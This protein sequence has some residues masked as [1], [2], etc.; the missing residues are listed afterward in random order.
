MSNANTTPIESQDSYWTALGPFVFNNYNPTAGLLYQNSGR[1]TGIAFGLGY[2][3]EK[4]LLKG[5]VYS[6]QSCHYPTRYI[7][8]QNYV[9]K[10]TLLTSGIPDDDLPD[11]FIFKIVP[12][13]VGGESVSFES[14]NYPNYYL[15][16]QNFQIKLHKKEE[17][18][19]DFKEDATFQ[20]KPGLANPVM[21]SFESVNFP[22]YFIHSDKTFNLKIVKKPNNEDALFNK[23]AT[24]NPFSVKKRMWV[25]T[26]NGGAW[27]SDDHGNSWRAAMEADQ[28]DPGDPH[29]LNTDALA[30]GAIAV[31]PADQKTIIVGSGEGN[32][33][34]KD[35]DALAF[36]G[37][38]Y[39]GMGPVRGDYNSGKLQWTLETASPSL[40]GEAFFQ[41][42][43]APDNE[44]LVIGATSQ[45]LY[46]RQKKGSDF[47]WKHSNL[48]N[49]QTNSASEPRV[50][51]VV[52]ASD[53]NT[54]TFFAACWG[55][56]IVYSNDDGK[57][58][59]SLDN[60]PDG[61]GRITL[62]VKPDDP[63]VVYALAAASD[64]S[65]LG[66][67]RNEKKDSWDG[68]K[69]LNKGVNK[70][71]DIFL[72][73]GSQGNYNQSLA[74]DPSD[75]DIFYL[76]G[77]GYNVFFCK[78]KDNKLSEKPV[79]IG[80]Y[81]GG[82]FSDGHA[83]A[84]EPKNF[85]S[86]LAIDLQALNSERLWFG[87]DGGL[88][89]YVPKKGE[90][91]KPD[92]FTQWFV[93]KNTGR[94]TLLS[95]RIGQHPKKDAV[96]Y[97]GAQDIPGQKYIG[98][99]A[100][101]F[102]PDGNNKFTDSGAVVVN[103]ADP[104]N[105]KWTTPGGVRVDKAPPIGHD[106]ERYDY[107]LKYPPFVG[108][109]YKPTKPEQANRL[110]EGVDNP[111]WQ[112]SVYIS[113][114]F[115]PDAKSFKSLFIIPPPNSKKGKDKEKPAIVRGARVRSLCFADYTTLYVG[116]MD[117]RIFRLADI[118]KDDTEDTKYTCTPTQLP[119]IPRGKVPI[120]S[121]AIDPAD[122]TGK[123][124]YVS[125]GGSTSAGRVQHYDGTNWES[126]SGDPHSHTGLLNIQ[127]NTIAIN[128]QKDPI[129][130]KPIIY[131]GTDIGVWYST[132]EGATWRPFSN[133]IPEVAV[134]NLK[135]Y[136]LIGPNGQLN[137]DLKPNSPYW[138]A[139]NYPLLR[140][141]TY[142][143]G[144]YERSLNP[145]FSNKDS[146]LFIR[147]NALDRGL[148][149]LDSQ[150]WNQLKDYTGDQNATQ[151]GTSPD[152]KFLVSGKADFSDISTGT[153]TDEGQAKK[154][155]E[156][157]KFQVDFS[158]FAFLRSSSKIPAAN[159]YTAI[160]TQVH[161]G[162]AAWPAKTT[163]YLLACKVTT[164]IPDCS[165]YKTIKSS[166]VGANIDKWTL[167]GKS[168]LSTLNLQPGTSAVFGFNVSDQLKTLK[169][170]PKKDI[171]CLLL[172][173]SD[174][175]NVF[176]ETNIRSI[177][178]N[179]RQAALSLI[180]GIIDP[181]DNKLYRTV[182]FEIKGKKQ[183]WMAE[184]LA[185]CDDTLRD[186]SWVYGQRS[187]QDYNRA[188]LEKYGRLYTWEGAQ[189]ACLPGWTV[190][191]KDDWENLA[192]HFGGYFDGFTVKPVGD[193]HKSY[194]NIIA[195]GSSGFQALLG[196]WYNADGFPPPGTGSLYWT[197]SI[198]EGDQRYAWYYGF[199]GGILSRR[200]NP[201]NYGSSVRCIM[202]P[203]L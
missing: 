37:L 27:Y 48:S 160:L 172:L 49:L 202:N 86:S 181:R 38:S 142:G 30:C 9:G 149:K 56:P 157:A 54:T 2:Q 45:G 124:V 201:L 155:Y 32:R 119:S 3:E 99:P 186:E 66:I 169:P 115:G 156:N 151:Y 203:V 47:V 179:N 109:P 165:N 171:L 69:D 92:K 162:G 170:D 100:W 70:L 46:I 187:P 55:G 41:L 166:K 122:S 5:E 173:I 135:I 78:V 25:A 197:S 154:I 52:V 145:N 146:R 76:S 88:H 24:F 21:V 63:N 11:D 121:I 110:A 28:F 198:N 58:W 73:H 39:F 19:D 177:V 34:F 133:G 129:T 123:S 44:T 161:N 196:G 26:A 82:V 93:N 29:K 144:I 106:E 159:E 158:E 61:A 180:G 113:D 79:N 194:T 72:G 175:S 81:P 12:G 94:N 140:A 118:K 20:I 184:N 60:F 96:L 87:D 138:D 174:G 40:V 163:A 80:Y 50:S 22:K 104:S 128:P 36:T 84:F 18:D 137:S 178:Q 126:R 199:G 176:S 127:H 75:V 10:I 15:R 114:D 164:S 105:V 67:Y 35:E 193:P 188:T 139:F 200:F 102:S 14:V 42:A 1:V 152:I 65:F 77:T 62:A 116:T 13:L 192:L 130:G 101:I 23:N 98:E 134:V 189:K 51:S 150:I 112:A 17:E 33:Y 125:L 91:F 131:V 185:Y 53:D 6:F 97:A 183:I 7:R 167:I 8:H 120:T 148:Y 136:P 90:G 83:L 191:S 57:E 74:V 111:S 195:G 71:G 132:D 143:R 4:E 182:E 59:K 85:R 16:H 89:I 103:W 95:E 168:S 68:W 108:T 64:N 43:W 31:C 107:Y 147:T 117:G 153:Y 141:A 190:A